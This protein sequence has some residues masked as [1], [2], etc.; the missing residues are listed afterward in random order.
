MKMK[1][2]VSV[3][4]IISAIAISSLNSNA[5]KQSLRTRTRRALVEMEHT[6]AKAAATKG[7]RDAFIEFLADDGIVFQP[8]PL[9][10]KKFWT[11][12]ER[13]KGLLSW[14]PEYADV[15]RAG[16]SAGQ[17]APGSFVRTVR[18]TNPSRSA[19]TSRFGKS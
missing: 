3:V 2:I 4:T 10:E 6:F 7:T 11:E 17:P 12:R 9:N 14:E 1:L 18:Q 16:I 19:S 8:G 13:R 5:Q 15:S